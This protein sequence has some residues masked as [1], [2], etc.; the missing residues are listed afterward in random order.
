M[1]GYLGIDLGTTGTKSMLFD[2]NCNVLGR[3]YQGYGL[4]T[5]Q[6]NFFEQDAEEWYSAVVNTVKTATKNFDGE[7]CGIS[8]SAQ[9]GSFLLCDLDGNGEIIPLTNALT[10]LDKRVD[11]NSDDFTQKVF[12]YNGLKIGAGSN[13]HKYNWLKVNKLDLFNKTKLVLSTSDYIYHRLT[14]KAVIDYT[15]AAMMGV[16]DS[17][18]Q[19]WDAGLIDVIGYKLEQFPKVIGAGEFIG[20]CNEKFL[21][22]TGL[23]GDVPV[24]SGVH[25]QFAASLGSNYFDD[26]DIIVSTGTTW[27]VFAKNKFEKKFG[28]SCRKHPANGYGYFCSAISSGTVL[29]WE[30]TFYTTDYDEINKQ[31]PLRK[32][33]KDLLV[34]PFVSGNGS[35]RGANVL[36]YSVENVD[37]NH[38]KFDVIKAS[39]EG[40]AFEIKEIINRYAFNGFNIGKIIVTGGATKSPAWMS[41]LSDVLGRTLYV[42]EQTD[43]CC[44]GAFSVAKKGAEG[45][46]T[47][48]N[49]TG[50]TVDPTE[51]TNSYQTKFEKYSKKF[52]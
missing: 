22:A 50:W 42:S 9:G 13:L 16:F 25:D 10:W 48:C 39:M 30:R 21:S 44:I 5:P 34:Y 49:F 40:V 43:G 18:I 7:I 26:N 29:N 20:Y 3:G 19:D 35:Y 4:I 31:V 51:L 45:S 52:N 23:K 36:K 24:Y 11:Q 32:F 8:F 41:I 28:F 17:K 46:F 12:D 2:E 27:V 14:G 6:E 1:K 38:D 47:T 33:D 15:S 37:Y